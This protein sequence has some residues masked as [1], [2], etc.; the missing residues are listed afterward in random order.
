MV[1]GKTVITED[2]KRSKD[3]RASVV[4]E[5]HMAIEGQL[6]DGPLVLQ[7]KFWMPRPKS[8]FR[9]TGGLTKSAPM[10]PTGKP[11]VTKLMRSTEDALKGVCWRDDSQIIDQYGCKRYANS[12]KS[13][14]AEITVRESIL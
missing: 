1:K 7:V 10:F 4:H 8:H 9:K 12:D 3:W 14:G 2:N 6:L 13:A 11:D 5:A